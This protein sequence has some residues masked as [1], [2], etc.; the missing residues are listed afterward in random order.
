MS[1][2]AVN[3]ADIYYE[4]RGAG[5]PVM[6]IS[7][8]T[9]DAGHF[10]RVADL[11]ADEFTVLTYDRRGNSRSPCPDGW[12]TTSVAEQ[13]DDAAAL[14]SGL[15]LAPAAVYGNSYGAIFA[16]DLLLR[17]PGVV[18]SAVLHE[19]PMISVLDDPVAAQASVGAAVQE[20]MAQ[21]GPPGAVDRFFRLAVGDETWDRLPTGLR[22][23]MTSNGETLVG[24]ELGTFESYRPDDSALAGITTPAH[25]LVS[26]DSPGFF[27][28]VAA[29]LAARA[30]VEVV[31]TPGSH[32][33]Q[34]DHP[35]ELVRT[36][37]PLLRGRT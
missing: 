23:R 19:P 25:V 10:E 13:V 12:E 35:D 6:F 3:G 4:L 24:M 2:I 33:P 36:I 32:T 22:D 26:E 16:L 1:S 34:F 37:R 8:A 18:R 29:W 15:G 31:R 30:G 5:P 27:H 14:L 11:L 21:G 7:G 28:E 20:G 17:R 9:G